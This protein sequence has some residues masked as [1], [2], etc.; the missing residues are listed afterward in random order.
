MLYANNAPLVVRKGEFESAAPWTKQLR[1]HF[2][3]GTDY[4]LRLPTSA[5]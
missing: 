1:V 3:Q 2:K 5:Q 4:E